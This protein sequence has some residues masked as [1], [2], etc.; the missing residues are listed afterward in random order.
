MQR[1]HKLFH[2]VINATQQNSSVSLKKV[3]G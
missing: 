1:I 3:T 2:E